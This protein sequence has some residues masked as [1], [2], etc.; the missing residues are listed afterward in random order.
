M[1]FVFCSTFCIYL[2]LYLLSLLLIGIKKHSH[3]LRLLGLNSLL[4]IAIRFLSTSSA[5]FLIIK[6]TRRLICNWA[7]SSPLDFAPDVS[8]EAFGCTHLTIISYK[9]LFLVKVIKIA[10][11]SHGH[12]RQWLNCFVLLEAVDWWLW[13]WTFHVLLLKALPMVPDRLSSVHTF[14]QVC[15]FIFFLS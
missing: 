13:L 11:A 7:F 10:D 14:V 3:F 12:E 15:H 1:F 6:P 5:I 4:T 8:I 9:W 2:P